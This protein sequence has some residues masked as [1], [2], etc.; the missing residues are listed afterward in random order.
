MIYNKS[1]GKLT[2]SHDHTYH[3][4][5]IQYEHMI[6]SIL[7]HFTTKQEGMV[8]INL[9]KGERLSWWGSIRIIYLLPMN[10]KENK[11]LLDLF[12]DDKKIYDVAIM[13]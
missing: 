9:S 10:C 13:M 7:L 6:G 1:K 8:M 5:H 12:L 3:T 4:P 2:A 11:I